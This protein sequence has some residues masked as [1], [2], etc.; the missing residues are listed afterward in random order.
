MASAK[1]GD[2]AG[3]LDLS[4]AN[5]GVWLMKVPQFVADRWHKAGDK[6]GGEAAAGGGAAQGAPSTPPPAAAAAGGGSVGVVGRVRMAFDPRAR[7]QGGQAATQFMMRL[8]VPEGAA[9]ELPVEYN[10]AFTPDHVPM[11]VF[12]ESAGGR[13]ALEGKV[14]HKFDMQPPSGDRGYRQML[15]TREKKWNT[16]KRTLSGIHQ[17][18]RGPACPCL[19]PS[20]MSRNYRF[21][22]T[23]DWSE[24]ASVGCVLRGNWSACHLPT[25]SNV[26]QRKAATT[27]AWQQAAAA[28]AAD[29]DSKRVR[30]SRDLVE[31]KLFA[32]FEERPHWTLK[33][34]TDATQQPQ[35][36]LKE[37]LGDMC[38]YNK[39]GPNQGLYE[40]KPEYKHSTQPPS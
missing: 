15:Q 34:L 9:A 37:V 28:R 38:V 6:P 10:L 7:P 29:K 25:K 17:G 24:F 12:S 2:G 36:F 8:E 32:L 23:P 39:R 27:P 40:L 22:W 20:P 5:Q 19:V 11:H 13:I 1:G 16:P 35:Q 26:S 31:A 14:E 3:E 4:R 21:W 33:H 18:P 30:M